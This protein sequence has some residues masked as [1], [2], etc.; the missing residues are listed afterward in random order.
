MY[1][2]TV[3]FSSWLPRVG[4]AVMTAVQDSRSWDGCCWHW[5]Y[6]SVPWELHTEGPNSI[7]IFLLTHVF[8]SVW[9]EKIFSVVLSLQITVVLVIVFMG[10]FLGVGY[11]PWLVEDPDSTLIKFN[12]RDKSSYQK[13]IETLDKYLSKYKNITATR[14]CTG[15]ESNAQLFS[16]GSAK[17][18]DLPGDDVVKVLVVCYIVCWQCYT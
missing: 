18:E 13:Y 7:G 10:I 6:I 15:D 3:S 2:T 16:D 4:N 5:L 12:V 1:W 14:I 11:Q 8:L 17:A 9:L